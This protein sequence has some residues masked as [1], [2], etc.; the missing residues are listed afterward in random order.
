[1]FVFEMN[2]MHKTKIRLNGYLI[3]ALVFV[4]TFCFFLIAY[5]YHLIRREQLNLFVYDWDYIFQTY[6][7]AGW[8]VRFV[9]SFFE[10]FFHLPVFGPLVVAALLTAIGVVVFKICRKFL[11]NVPSYVIASLVFI[12]SF[13]RET[14]NLFV[15][16]YTMATLGFL[17]LL[18]LAL[19]P[20]QVWAKLLSVILLAGFGI[21]A[22]GS[23]VNKFYGKPWG[24]PRIA[25]DRVIGLE[26]AVARENWDRVLRLSKKDLYMVEASLCYNIA[27]AKK[28]ELGNTLFDHSQG[29]VYNFLLPVSGDNSTFTNTLAGELWYQ[30]GDMTIAEQS[31]ITALQA[32]PEHTGAR[33]ILR[34]ANANLK[35][36]ETGSAQKYLNILSKTLFYGKWARSMFPET[37]DDM[38]KARLEDERS[39]L[40]VTDFVHLSDVPRSVLLGIL[41]S[42][43]CNNVAREFL[44]CFDL[45]RYDLDQFVEEYAQNRIDGHIYKEA[46]LIY[47]SRENKLNEET[48]AEYGI[49]PALVSR[50]QNFFRFPD[51]YKN[52]Y[53]YF[54][55]KAINENN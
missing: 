43:P 52:T 8:L 39:R 40:A 19:I 1:M 14:G 36:G 27:Q 15:T 53:W 45:M 5:P 47:L 28:G 21:W 18:Y 31:A 25:Y 38:T 4:C 12:W 11:G 13:M 44:Y 34:L 29:E 10:Q 17:F 6:R 54:Y 50:M 51:R 42:D 55:L 9:S 46:V 24:L 16:R 2:K 35:K 37:Q 22:L 33:F 3:A 49:D 30:V 41:E 7:G 26:D 48:V 32:S 23:P 20:K